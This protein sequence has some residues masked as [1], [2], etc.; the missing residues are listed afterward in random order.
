MSA[1]SEPLAPVGRQSTLAILAGAAVLIAILGLSIWT[2]AARLEEQSR[3]RQA[4]LIAN[5]L[6]L[7]AEDVRR[8]IASNVIWDEAVRNLDLKFDPKWASD[9]I[10]NYFW[11]FD[12]Y[13]SVFI[14]DGGGR[15]VFAYENGKATDLHRYDDLAA[16]AAPM[17]AQIRRNERRRG[18]DATSKGSPSD[19]ID[20]ATV[21]MHAGQPYLIAASLVQTDHSSRTV[22]SPQGAIVIVGDAIDKDF[23][24]RLTRRYLLT[25]LVVAPAHAATPKGRISTP[26]RD[27]QGREIARLIW[28]PT[29]SIGPLVRRAGPLLAV[30]LLGLLIFTGLLIRH[31]RQRAR[32]LEKA[33]RAA[34]E[35][36]DAKSAF[37][38]TMSHEIRTPLNGILGMAQAIATDE[39]TPIQRGRVGVI[40]SSGQ[41]LLDILNDVL[42]LSKIESGKLSLE[43]VEF[44]LETL[45][46][47]VRN[48]FDNVA[49]EKGLRFEVNLDG[50]RGVYRGDPVRVRQI[51]FNLVSNAMKFTDA[52]E[53]VLSATADN[54]ALALR[55]ADT[56]I[57]IAP[58]KL[59]AIFGKFSQADAST[60]RRYGGS[61]LGLAICTDLV[62]L[63]G[64]RIEVTSAVGQGSCFT[65]TIVLPRLSAES[66]TTPAPRVVETRRDL[67]NLRVLAAEDNPTNQQVLKALL[68]ALGIEPTIVGDGAQ[69]YDAWLRE[70]WDLVLMD[71]QMPVMDGLEAT[72]RIRAT[73]SEAKMRR[74]RIVALTADAMAHQY[75]ACLAAGMDGRLT[76]PIDIGA[77]FETI[78]GACEARRAAA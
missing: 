8:S 42:D 29:D 18:T 47:D 70:D 66:A 39:L 71:V 63:M 12:R 31:E 11:R 53:V 65:A 15:P 61:G 68:G 67:S 21:V 27:I 14:L 78:A 50:A 77:L 36:S 49:V 58:D 19:P 57:G 44:D 4:R 69:A 59:A 35:A 41:A 7:H 60:T 23:A 75:D 22:A 3:E 73:E 13:Q 16:G 1:T 33:M 56:G 10:G 54:D 43:E 34:R 30:T 17:I 51:L 20:A 72:R 46:A 26:L 5:G 37:L 25:N 55:V 76:K 6:I 24:G 45:V 9:Y 74:T 2:G 38:A 48:C 62:E 32:E 64:G 28:R 52:G 40:R